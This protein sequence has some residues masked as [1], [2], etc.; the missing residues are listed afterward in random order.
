MFTLY[1][2]NVFIVSICERAY[3]L[4]KPSIT[5]T[6]SAYKF[7][8][9]HF[10]IFFKNFA[11][12][13]AVSGCPASQR[14]NLFPRAHPKSKVRAL[15]IRKNQNGSKKSLIIIIKLMNHYLQPRF[16]HLFYTN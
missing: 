8:Q 4:Q 14:A 5:H 2:S 15:L 11:K 3:Y 12:H 13:F 7:A 16:E 6:C 10:T 1:S 9:K